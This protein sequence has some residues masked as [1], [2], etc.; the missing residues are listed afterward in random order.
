[1]LLLE[2]T[3]LA[4]YRLVKLSV[5]RYISKFDQTFCTLIFFMGM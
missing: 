3:V 5:H 1:L 4:Y 2:I